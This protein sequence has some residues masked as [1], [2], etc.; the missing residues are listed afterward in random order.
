M[1]IA[2]L[3]EAW[4][5]SEQSQKKFSG[6]DFSYLDNKMDMEKLNW[7]YPEIVSSYLKPTMN[8]LDMGTGGGELLQSFKHPYDKTAVTEG[9]DKNYQLLMTTLKPLGIDIQFVKDD[10]YLNF[11]DDSFDIVLNSHESFSISEVQRVLKPN[12]IFITQQ[13]GDFNGVNLASRL[14]P[15][16]KKEG[17]DFHLSIVEAQLKKEQFNILFKNEQYLKQKFY[18]MDGLIYYVRT[19]PW[20]Y[21]DFSVENSLEQLVGLYDELQRTG[22]IYNLQHRFVLVARNKKRE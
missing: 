11:P 3:R 21:T 7:S 4:I 1:N 16:Y 17:F 18:D 5:K 20:E 13:V 2:K 14:I 22:F 8:L 10:D 6:W 12:G 9:Y 19:I 15:N